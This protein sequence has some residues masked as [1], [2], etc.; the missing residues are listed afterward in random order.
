MK[1]LVTT[2]HML[3]SI[4]EVQNES[5]SL[6]VLR[7]KNYKVFLRPCPV[8]RHSLASSNTKQL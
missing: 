5:L 3:P 4:L 8:E 7:I 2:E 6:N 1:V